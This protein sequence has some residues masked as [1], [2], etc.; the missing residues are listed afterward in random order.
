MLLDDLKDRLK[1]EAAQFMDRFQESSL[2]LSLKDRY[3][4]LSPSRQRLVTFGGAGIC[5]LS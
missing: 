3:D 4:S 5:S 2:Y 1:G